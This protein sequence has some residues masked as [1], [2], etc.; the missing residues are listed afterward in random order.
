[1][2]ET[3]LSLNS[4]VPS[5]FPSPLLLCDCHGIA[6]VLWW[7]NQEF[8]SADVIPTWVSLLTCHLGVGGR[9]SET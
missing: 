5:P 1:M 7:T 6:R 4:S 2:R 3:F 8:S 9:N